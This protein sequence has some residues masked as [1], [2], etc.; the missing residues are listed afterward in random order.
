ML[1]KVIKICGVFLMIA[2]IGVSI[3]FYSVYI[4]VERIQ[5]QYET[6]QSTKIPEDFHDVTIA[7]ITDIQF[8]QFMTYDRL[9]NMIQKINQ[10][11]PDIL[12]FG[13]D[14]F[15][16]TINHTP[17]EQSTTQ[18]IELLKSLK[19]PLGKFAVL[20]ERDL[21]N[22]EIKTRATRILND[23][24]FE[25]ITNRSLRLHN[26]SN[27]SITLIGLDSLINGK[28]DYD[29]AFQGV[30]NEEFNIAIT[31]CPDIVNESQ[32][33]L[34]SLDL[35]FAGHSHASQISLPLIGPLDTLEGAQMYNHGNYYINNTT[36]L[37]VSNGLGTTK[38]DMRL[39]SLP[40]VNIYRL[41]HAT[42][43]VLP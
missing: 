7:F 10:S 32:I 17:S 15:E 43:E 29:V 34:A 16:D 42:S 20:G 6:I 3:F 38:L 14:L 8:G 23:S 40:Q 12:L 41:Q 30:S 27:A 28:P 2:F 33:P 4:A 39:F 5:I 35:I 13:G 25:I 26:Q 21:T 36:K 18:L 9:A 37:V 24:D 1:K 11:H 19:A 31:H 22:E